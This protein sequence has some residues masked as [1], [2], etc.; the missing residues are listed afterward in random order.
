MVYVPTYLDLASE[1]AFFPPDLIAWQ[2]IMLA[3]GLC[4]L[5]IEGF[6]SPPQHEAFAAWASRFQKQY[7]DADKYEGALRTYLVNDAHIKSVNG[8]GL[9]YTLAHNQ[10]VQ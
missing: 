2:A 4:L 1:V 8:C 9:S 3:A 7:V 5:A 6:A 10:S